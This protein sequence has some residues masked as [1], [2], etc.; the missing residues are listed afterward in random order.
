MSRGVFQNSLNV[1]A[2]PSFCNGTLNFADLNGDDL[3]DI[4]ITGALSM[5]GGQYLYISFQY[6]NFTFS[7]NQLISF[8][9]RSFGVSGMLYSSVLIEDFSG[10]GSLEIMMTGIFQLLNAILYTQNNQSKLE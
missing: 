8:F 5:I 7:S 9:D 2:I 1:L 10:D 4:F 3:L 6:E